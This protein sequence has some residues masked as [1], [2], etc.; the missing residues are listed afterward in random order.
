MNTLSHLIE[1][2]PARAKQFN[3]TLA[4]VYRYILQNKARDL[5]LLRDEMGF[6]E[7]YFLLLKI[8]F[9]NAVQLEKNVEDAAL[10]YFLVPPISLQLLAENAIKHNEFSEESPLVF[11]I[12]L[13]NEELLVKN[14]LY[15]KELRKPSSRI[16]LHNLNERYKLVT[17]K[18]I[19]S[20]EENG[21][22]TVK[23][24]VLRLA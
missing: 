9:E 13:E 1:E 7:S 22:F 20:F 3:D 14:R 23:L 12:T 8:R 2:Q 18:E 6:L 11:S 24:P 16:G 19:S 15:K 21:A 10:E 5:V 4:D 17:S